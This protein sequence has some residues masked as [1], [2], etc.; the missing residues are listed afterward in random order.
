MVT[1]K[2]VAS[3][4]VMGPIPER[5]AQSAIHVSSTLRPSGETTPRPVMTTRRVIGALELFVDVVDGLLDGQ[6]LF[7]VLI[8]DFNAEFLFERH[9][10]FDGVERVGA[11]I[12]HEV[13]FGS[14][15]LFRS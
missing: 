10:Q 7:G 5:P 1:G 13:G 9:H 14:Y 15:V 11:E 12:L 3:K 2:S 8:G 6:N 4:R